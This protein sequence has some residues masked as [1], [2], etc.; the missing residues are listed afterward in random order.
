MTIDPR[1]ESDI[2]NAEGC[3]L[4]AYKDTEGFWTVGYGHKLPLGTDYSGHSITADEAL[5]F[6]DDDIAVA[7]T[8]ATSLPE[9]P[10][11]DSACRRN[12]IIEL[13]FNMHGHWYGFH[14]C[15]AALA[16]QKWKTAHDDLLDSKWAVQVG[17]TRSTRLA[18]YILNGLYPS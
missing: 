2:K 13:S 12:A 3:N 7:I 9:Y 8:F 16:A 10:A 17:P 18:N 6:L 14:D 4:A 15:R 11:L 5:R 1:L